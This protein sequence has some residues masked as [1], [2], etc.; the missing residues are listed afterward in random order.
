MGELNLIFFQLLALL[1][2]HPL[3]LL[4]QM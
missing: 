3:I 1:T 2:L 4:V